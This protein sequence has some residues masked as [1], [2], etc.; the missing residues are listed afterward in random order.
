LPCQLCILPRREADMP[1]ALV[2][3]VGV[4]RDV[5]RSL[6]MAIRQ[7]GPDFVLFLC[8]PQS[9]TYADRVVREQSLPEGA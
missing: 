2:L 3:T 4:G 1:K 9:R 7:Y 5:D 8:S 6:T